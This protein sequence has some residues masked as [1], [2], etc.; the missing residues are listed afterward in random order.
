MRKA[1]QKSVSREEEEM[2]K[3]RILIAT[4]LMLSLGMAAIVPPAMACGGDM[5]G[6]GGASKPVSSPAEKE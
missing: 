6:K 2:M 4:I 3:T 1:A 5:K